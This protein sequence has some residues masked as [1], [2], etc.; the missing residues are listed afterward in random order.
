VPQIRSQV[1]EYATFTARERQTAGSFRVDIQF[2]SGGFLRRSGSGDF[3]F[4]S[5]V[6]L[7][8]LAFLHDLAPFTVVS[9]ILALLPK[10]EI[11]TNSDD[12]FIET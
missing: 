11:S 12:L 3:K 10:P 1:V 8:W 7:F 5:F 4:I 9:G 2:L 6:F